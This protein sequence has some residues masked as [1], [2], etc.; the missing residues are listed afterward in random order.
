[1][2]ALEASCFINCWC[3]ADWLELVGDVKWWS[4]VEMF[5]F[6]PVRSLKISW[7]LANRQTRQ[8][9]G[10]PVSGG[11][12]H[13]TRGGFLRGEGMN[14]SAFIS[15]CAVC[16]LCFVLGSTESATQELRRECKQKGEGCSP[17]LSISL[18]G[19]MLSGTTAEEREA[20]NSC[21]THLEA[22]QWC[23]NLLKW[24]SSYG[25]VKILWNGW[26]CWWYVF[27][28]IK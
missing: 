27:P 19:K 14:T 17:S 6:P 1:M 11:G 9:V 10:L 26:F 8:T 5:L 18:K 15:L 3:W 2:F 22:W 25:W 21:C 28:L 4:D 24:T 16:E 13:Q 20:N 12:K 23:F 7:S